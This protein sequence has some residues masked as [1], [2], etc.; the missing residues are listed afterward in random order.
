[1]SGPDWYRWYPAKWASGVIGLTPEQRGVYMDVINIILDRGECPED[2]GYLAKACNCRRDKVQR[3][4]GALVDKGKLH[5][6]AGRISQ[7]T[8]EKERNISRSLTDDQRKIANSRWG[9]ARK[10]SD[11]GDT[12]R[13][14][15]KNHN[16]KRDSES[17]RDSESEST[18]QQ[19]RKS[20]APNGAVEDL[21]REVYRVGRAILGERSGAQ[22][23]KLRRAIGNDQETLGLLW[24]AERKDRPAE[25]IAAVIKTRSKGPL[26]A[27]S[28]L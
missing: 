8:A 16:H 7:R 9:K 25:W 12:T 5:L 18:T 17:V 23:T 20:D 21:E 2:Y 13:H 10:N 27:W 22:I 6:E 1:M 14:M 11:L 26:P 24:Q 19:R 28:T 4:V 3:I 15:P